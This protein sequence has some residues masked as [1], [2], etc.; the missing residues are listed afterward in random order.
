MPH[1]GSLTAVWFVV[2]ILPS[3]SFIFEIASPVLMATGTGSNCIG[4]C[5]SIAKTL[6]NLQLFWRLAKEV[7][8]T[9]AV[10]A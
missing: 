2:V 7:P 10:F 9:N 5:T 4:T 1:T 8:A 3:P 6:R